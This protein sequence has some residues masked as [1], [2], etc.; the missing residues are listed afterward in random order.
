MC[1]HGPSCSLE[2]QDALKE[3]DAAPFSAGISPDGILQLSSLAFYF[4]FYYPP[5]HPVFF[6]SCMSMF[7]ALEMQEQREAVDAAA[8]IAKRWEEHFPLG[9]LLSQGL[10]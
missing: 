10:E 2:L 5:P 3:S 6:F 4:S 9:F 7:H 1:P 8:L